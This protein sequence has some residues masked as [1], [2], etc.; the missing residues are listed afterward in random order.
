MEGQLAAAGPL[1][2]AARAEKEQALAAELGWRYYLPEAAQE[3]QVRAQLDRLT[4]GPAALPELKV[5]DPCMGS[6]HILVYVFEVLMQLYEREGWNPRDAAQSILE[7]NLYGLDIDGRAAQLAYFA[8]MMKARRYDRR[9][10][11]RGIQPH[12]CAIRESNAL[13]AEALHALG[14]AL[15]DGERAAALRQAALPDGERAAALRQAE[16]LVQVFCNAREYGSILTVPPL[17]WALL[18]RFAASLPVQDSV[19][20]QELR[21]RSAAEQLRQLIAQGEM[22]ARQYDVVVTNPPYMGSSGMNAKLADFVGV[23]RA[24]RADDRPGALPG[25]DHPACLDV[26][27]QL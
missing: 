3:P 13:P 1:T 21:A 9:I 24:L 5:I 15:P 16:Q 11:G 25:N 4:A 20:L 8:V 12:V 7:H 27:F 2:E 18:R 19:S 10:L 23:Y 17:D 22:M 26:P 6:G 14:A